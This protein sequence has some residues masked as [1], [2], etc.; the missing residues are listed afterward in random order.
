MQ[1]AYLNYVPETESVGADSVDSR[2]LPVEARTKSVYQ[3]PTAVRFQYAYSPKPA[4]HVEQQQQYQHQQQLQQTQQNQEQ[5]LISADEYFELIRNAEITRTQP[6]QGVK[7]IYTQAGPST[8]ESPATVPAVAFV[9]PS[10]SSFTLSD[11]KKIPTGR[12][13]IPLLQPQQ[14]VQQHLPPSVNR[15][16]EY[17]V[18]TQ[19]DNDKDGSRSAAAKKYGTETAQKMKFES[20]RNGQYHQEVKGKKYIS[21]K[22]NYQVVGQTSIGQTQQ[23]SPQHVQNQQIVTYPQAQ[24]KIIYQPQTQSPQTRYQAVVQPTQTAPQ[25]VYQDSNIAYNQFLPQTERFVASVPFSPG[26]GDDSNGQKQPEYRIQYVSASQI[27]QR[28]KILTKYHP[29]QTSEQVSARGE[30]QSHRYEYYDPESQAK[31][32]SQTVRIVQPPQLQY[33]RPQLQQYASSAPVIDQQQY[34]QKKVK[35]QQSPSAALQQH[36]EAS[37]QAPQPSRSSIFVSQSTGV[38]GESPS[39]PG[40][41]GPALPPSAQSVYSPATQQQ[42][43]TKPLPPLPLTNPKKP[44]TQAEF[45]ALVDAGYKLQAIPVPVPVPVSAEK[46]KLIQQQQQQRQV[47]NYQPQ[48]HAPSHHLYATQPIQGQVPLHQHKTYIQPGH[49]HQASTRNYVR[50]EPQ[51]QQ[52][53]D[54]DENI[55]TSYLRPLIEYIGGPK[56]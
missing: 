54:N 10:K 53:Q 4:V 50:L 45:Q 47:H 35:Y 39:A 25:S 2:D 34:H 21:L 15:H 14:F 22:P 13:Q 51:R 55:F 52:A 16:A 42:Q 43:R 36:T 48:A 5:Q 28:A 46:Y 33:E 12:P 56:S 23:Y 41:N 38:G 49:I 9:T 44:I 8:T 37:P 1:V 32:K 17:V 24:Q 20:N 30:Q 40:A 3:S 27:P 6:I 7:T 26:S 11:Y 18:S 29:E 31:E 19:D